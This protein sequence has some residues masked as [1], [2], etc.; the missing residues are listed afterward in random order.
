MDYGLRFSIAPLLLVA[1]ASQLSVAQVRRDEKPFVDGSQLSDEGPVFDTV[2]QARRVLGLRRQAADNPYVL[3]PVW[4][5]EESKNEPDMRETWELIEALQVESASPVAFARSAAAPPTL[6]AWMW[7]TYPS[8]IF[9]AMHWQLWQPPPRNGTAITR[10]G[11][12]MIDEEGR[13][14]I[15]HWATL[16][17]QNAPPLDFVLVDATRKSRSI[18]C[19]TAGLLKHVGSPLWTH[20]VRKYGEE[21]NADAFPEVR[22][23]FQCALRV[24][25]DFVQTSNPQDALT[26]SE[27]FIATLER[28]L[29]REC[30]TDG[31]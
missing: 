27:E 15:C 9:G 13:P 4:S 11:L 3:L 2:E 7:D 24:Q 21:Q 30:L 31:T 6:V 23:L 22:R 14:T 1:L 5:N 8:N 12:P 29:R 26:S 20:V 19:F 16:Q 17:R 18:G 10:W 28:Q 25:Y